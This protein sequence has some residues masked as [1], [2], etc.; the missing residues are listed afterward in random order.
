[1]GSKEDFIAYLG[2]L[3]MYVYCKLVR[4]AIVDRGV[5]VPGRAQWW[6]KP[7]DTR[8]SWLLVELSSFLKGAGDGLTWIQKEH[9]LHLGLAYQ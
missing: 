4:H 7:R 5:I 1:M 3:N 2:D 6:W 9:C 8:S